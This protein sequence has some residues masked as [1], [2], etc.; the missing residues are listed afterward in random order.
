MPFPTVTISRIWRQ[1]RPLL[2][3]AAVSA[4]LLAPVAAAANG[5]ALTG[6]LLAAAALVGCCVAA[7]ARLFFAVRPRLGTFTAAA[8]TCTVSGS[9]LLLVAVAAPDCP[10]GSGRCSAVEVG[11]WTISGVLV[12]LL[13]FLLGVLAPVS[14]VLRRLLAASTRLP[15]RLLTRTAA[16]AASRPAT[17]TTSPRDRERRRRDRRRA[18]RARRR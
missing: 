17:G 18:R 2:A 13:V 3:G 6:P 9:F 8:A 16:A 15:R 11:A 12:S 1:L 10:G 7:I 14:R 5:V 4:G